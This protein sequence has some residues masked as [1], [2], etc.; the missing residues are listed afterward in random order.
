MQTAREAEREVIEVLEDV[1]SAVCRK[2]AWEQCLWQCPGGCARGSP[3]CARAAFR[4]RCA[5]CIQTAGLPAHFFVEDT[6]DAFD[7]A[8]VYRGDRAGEDGIYRGPYSKPSLSAITH[9]K[10]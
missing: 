9:I 8:N 1:L 3:D 2:E 10:I 5:D 6:L 4:T 7:E